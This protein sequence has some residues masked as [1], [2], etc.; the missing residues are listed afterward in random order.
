MSP[1]ALAE[2]AASLGYASLGITDGAD[3]GGVVKFAVA[4]RERGV[5]PIVGVELVVDGR[6]LALLA[7]TAEG[8][9]NL[10]ALV[11]RARSGRV[12]EWTREDAG[13][14]AGTP[15]RGRPRVTWRDVAE[16]A[17]GVTLLTGPASGR[18]AA[19]VRARRGGEARRLLHEWREAF[20]GEAYVEV[21][22]HFAGRAEAAL[23]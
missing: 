5:K 22:H 19:L 18:L 7:R 2:R 13:R 14:R 9:R 3:L 11:T 23:A 20:A 4:C 17:A 21:Q 10:A 16:R 6:P 15:P 12:G 8:Y 1:E